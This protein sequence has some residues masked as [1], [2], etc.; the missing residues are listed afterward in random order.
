MM[1]ALTMMVRK[2]LVMPMMK[3]NMSSSMETGPKILYSGTKDRLTA[4]SINPMG[5]SWSLMSRGVSGKV[6]GA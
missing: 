5:S 3:N 1:T 2:I 6:T 4:S